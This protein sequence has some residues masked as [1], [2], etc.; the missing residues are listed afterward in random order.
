MVRIV[1]RLLRLE[2]DRIEVGCDMVK[3]SSSNFEPR[4][5]AVRVVPD[6]PYKRQDVCT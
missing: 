2:V 6:T 3:V 5:N 4:T 1:V